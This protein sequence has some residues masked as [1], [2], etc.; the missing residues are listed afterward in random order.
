MGE[1]FTI[2]HS[3]LDPRVFTELLRLR[4]VSFVADVRSVPC[5]RH[6]SAYIGRT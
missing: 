5:S 6:V 4:G 3:N 2:G 1:L